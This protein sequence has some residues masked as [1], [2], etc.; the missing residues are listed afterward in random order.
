MQQRNTSSPLAPAVMVHFYRGVMDLATTW[1]TRVDGT[2][3]WAVV[4]AGS[5]ASFLLSD[6]DH[7]HLMALLGMFLAFAFLAIEARRFR[8]YDLWSGWLRLMETDY[9]APVLRNNAIEARQQW[10]PLL[11]ADLRN[12]HFKIS[13]SEA[14]GRR[15]RHN[16]VAIFGFL[17]LAWLVKLLPANAPAPNECATIV[18]CA[19]IGPIPGW[20]VMVSVVLFYGYLLGLILFTPKLVGTGTELIERHMLFRR[21]VAPGAQLVGFKRHQEV[22]YI[23]DGVAL[24]PE[25]D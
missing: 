6:P 3:N 7:P 19:R 4:S 11:V 9:Y 23:V 21:L 18:E 20:L 1:R 15:L 17:L 10:H 24:A 12:P 13:W 14:M 8:F 5:I 2:T 25:E 16:Y 22:P